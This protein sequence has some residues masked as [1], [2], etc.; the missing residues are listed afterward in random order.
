MSYQQADAEQGKPVEA[1]ALAE[2]LK[3]VKAAADRAIKGRVRRVPSPCMPL[4]DENVRMSRHPV[5]TDDSIELTHT[6]PYRRTL[7][8]TRP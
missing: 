1:P 6:T 2:Q 3:R 4:P 5:T 8:G 7:S